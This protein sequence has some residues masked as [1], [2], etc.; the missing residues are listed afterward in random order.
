MARPKSTDDNPL[1]E[2]L[3]AP[4]A[5]FLNAM[6]RDKGL[7]ANTLDA[8]RRDLG[9]YLRHLVQQGVE[10]V[11]TVEQQHVAHL[12]HSLREAGLSPSTMARNLTSIKRFHQYLLLQGATES[13]PAENLD[14]PKLERKLPDV[15]TVDELTALLAT[16]DAAEPLGQRDHAILEV[17]YATGLRVSEL[18][19]LQ[20][21]ALLLEHGL[22]RVLSPGPRERL[23]PIG[24]QAI[25]T[26][27]RYLQQSRPHLARPDTGDHVF[28]NNQGGP[29][30]RMSIWKIIK[31]AGDKS[32]IDKKEVSPHTLR[33]T[34]A[35]HLLEG[36]ANLRDVQEL[37][38]HADIS[39]TQI[40]T[41][42]DRSYLKE[43][44]KTYHPR[45]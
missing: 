14:P 26:L 15:L 9:R 36:G 13:N 27:T 5:R 21:A 44:H 41:Q 40:Y 11:E 33:H 35:T 20:R 16:P 3:A 2:P 10:R 4:L 18:T 42:L 8:Y 12:L 28:L 39:T 43:V 22:V 7:A 30:S 45:G 19:A 31:T 24:P 34:F 17:L 23:V 32:K 29:L 1:P 38:G 37:L 25:R 6:E